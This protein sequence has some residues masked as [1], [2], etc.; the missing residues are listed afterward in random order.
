[1]VSYK[2]YKIKFWGANM[3]IKICLINPSTVDEHKNA[4]PLST[5]NKYFLNPNNIAHVGLGYIASV[6]KTAG[7][8]CDVIELPVEEIGAREAVEIVLKKKYTVVGIS[9]YYYNFLN[10]V[11]IIDKLKQDNPDIFIWV[12]GLLPTLC[13]EELLRTNLSCDC[14]MVGEGEYTALE[15]IRCLSAD[16]AWENIS[17]LV[18]RRE[19]KIFRN[20]KRLLINKLDELP[21]PYRKHVNNR[22]IAAIVTSR[23]CYGNCIYCGIREYIEQCDG[24]AYRRRS[25]ENVV[26][27][28]EELVKND[29]VSIIVF[30]DG[31]FHIASKQGMDWFETFEKLIIEK[32]IRV[33][34][35]CDFRA[36]EIVES[37]NIVKRFKHLGLFNVN[38]GIES[39]IQKQLD[40]YNKKITVEQNVKAIKI[41]ESLKLNYTIGILL[42]DPTSTIEEIIEFCNNSIKSNYYKENYNINRPF[43]VG[44]RVVATTGTALFNFVQSKGL[45]AK[46][47]YNYCFEDERLEEVFNVIELWSE[48]VSEVFNLNYVAYISSEQGLMEIDDEIRLLYKALFFLD[49][50]YIIEACEMK[51]RFDSLDNEEWKEYDNAS[52]ENVIKIESRLKELEQILLKFY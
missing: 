1:M 29:K 2:E 33:Q 8:Q 38:I 43:S 36:N 31:V 15:L 10:T 28:I 47:S 5:R 19:N 51:I 3:K 39:F 52:V 12:G 25:P 18:Y 32:G 11:R 13:A 27:E 9:T 49:R 26:W 44:S 20:H 4:S 42:F 45:Y 34:F 24:I 41:I 35:L 7:F 22:R 30:N 48:K 50:A 6:L 37:R 23:G 16:E 21:F 17:G 40:F 14:C 46:N